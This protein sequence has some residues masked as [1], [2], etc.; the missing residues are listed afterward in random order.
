VHIEAS[1][2]QLEMTKV[3]QGTKWRQ[4]AAARRH[5]PFKR[6]I[7]IIEENLT[8]AYRAR[9]RAARGDIGA[10]V[11]LRN[12]RPAPYHQAMVVLVAW[13]AAHAFPSYG[14][15]LDHEE[16]TLINTSASIGSGDANHGLFKECV[17]STK[18]LS[19]SEPA[20][21]RVWVFKIAAHSFGGTREVVRGWR[22]R[23]MA[24]S[25]MTSIVRRDSS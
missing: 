6:V 10:P 12:K 25:V 21:T 17:D 20:N 8:V 2:P 22:Q 9:T 7:Y 16:G 19:K 4:S 15:M 13:V 1:G 5:T 14:Q 11:D 3:R 18:K 24:Y 23:P